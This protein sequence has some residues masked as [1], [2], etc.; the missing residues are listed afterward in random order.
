MNDQSSAGGGNGSG[1]R[2]WFNAL[3]QLFSGEPRD[4]DEMIEVLRDCH[5]RNLVDAD[6]LAMIEGALHVSEMRV[7]DV[8]I[9]RAQMA[10][11]ESDA[12]P[13]KIVS[14]VA[15]SGH[16]RF[17]VIGDDRDDVEGVLLA[18]DLVRYLA[19]DAPSFHLRDVLRP[20]TVI[21]E[22]K[23]LNV[24][25]QDFRRSRNHLAIVVDEYGGVAGLV[26]IED[27]LEQIVG[28]IGDEHD[29]DEEGLILR[30]TGDRYTVKAIT[31]IDEFNEFF[32]A[33]FSDQEFDTVGGMVSAELGRM[34]QRGDRV[35]VGHFQFEVLRADNR[36]VHLLGM[37]LARD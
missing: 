9:P 31:P 32:D 7:R 14:K 4:R 20:A 26:T 12:T 18:K 28:D 22:S 34:P 21:P 19:E 1:H 10:V 36:R 25:L 11:I 24:L 6:A 35:T 17:P 23:R 33:A 27:V 8:M 3:T 29:I 15:E 37:K 2:S 30:H 16:S 5:E 13:E